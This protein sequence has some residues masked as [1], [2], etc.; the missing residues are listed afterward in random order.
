MKGHMVQKH[1]NVRSTKRKHTNP[2]ALRPPNPVSIPPSNELHIWVHHI[3]K[4]YTDDT[5]KFPV[6]SRT[7]NQ[8]IM[9]AYHC[10]SN[11]ILAVPF[12]LRKDQHRLQ[13]YDKIMQ[14]LTDRG[15]IVDLQILDNEASAAY[16]RIITTKCEVTFQLAPPHIHRR[17]SAE[18]A[19][20]T[21]KANFLSILAGVA[22]EYPQNLWDLLLPQAVLT[23]NLSRQA[24][25][26]PN[27]S[28][29]EFLEGTLDY[30]ANPLAHPG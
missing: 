12:T 13:A 20:R 18:R 30:N 7:G 8:Y 4:L 15:M 1:Q 11:A 17:N 14:Q 27:V 16:K 24:T 21:F 19:I 26:N 22:N 25:L 9:V 29:W 23:L 28:A 2:T 3:S 10:D 6:R 5:G